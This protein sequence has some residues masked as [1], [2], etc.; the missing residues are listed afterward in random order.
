MKTFEKLQEHVFLKD[1]FVKSLMDL[2]GYTQEQAEGEVANAT[3]FR[4]VTNIALTAN[5]Q[6]YVVKLVDSGKPSQSTNG[7]STVNSNTP[8]YL[9]DEMTNVENRSI[10][11]FNKIQVLLQKGRQKYSY[12]NPTIFPKATADGNINEEY[13]KIYNGVLSIGQGSNTYVYRLP[14]FSA[15]M[16]PETQLL[17]L[18]GTSP[19]APENR[20]EIDYDEAGYIFIGDCL[21]LKGGAS[22]DLTINLPTI[23]ANSVTDNGGLYVACEGLIIR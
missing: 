22:Y 23:F 12:P 7:A 21:A 5:S 16:I 20:D 10:F 8:Y 1:R 9:A 18:A 6:T 19:V 4:L 3:P 2:N 14:L 13:L 11:I 17:A 15:Y